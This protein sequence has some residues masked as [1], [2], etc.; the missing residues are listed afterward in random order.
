MKQS[1]PPKRLSVEQLEDRSTPSFGV[2]WFDATSLTLSFVPDG[3]IIS[4][5]PSNLASQLGNNASQ[6]QWQKEILRAY[7]SW[8][9]EA[10]I[11]VGLAADGGQA[12]GTPG[13]TGTIRG[14]EFEVLRTLNYDL[15]I[16]V[17]P[18]SFVSRSCG[19]VL[20]LSHRGGP[21]NL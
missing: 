15:R 4:G 2:P 11:N 10:N 18:A 3:T 13:A 16:L 6:Q 9:V 20:S 14:S 1:L 12:M 8:A 5:T 21:L 7:Q 19:S 17:R